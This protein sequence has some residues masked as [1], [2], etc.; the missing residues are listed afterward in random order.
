MVKINLKLLNE[1]LNLKVLKQP[2][3]IYSALIIFCISSISFYALEEKT[4]RIKVEKQLVNTQEEKRIV[5][6]NLTETLQAKEQVEKELLSE[7]EKSRALV[8]EVEEKDRQIKVALDRI[9]QE[10]YA[11]KKSE[12]QLLLV[13]KGKTDPKEILN[14]SKQNLQTV[15][16][17]KIE[18]EPIAKR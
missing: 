6:N 1:P 12:E 14:N 11:R 8:K 10:I 3:V 9:E 4:L 7:K 5:E 16:L 17:E 18:I 15:E 2:K 13:T